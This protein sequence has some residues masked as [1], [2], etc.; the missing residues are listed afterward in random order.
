MKNKLSYKKC[1]FKADYEEINKELK[2]IDWKLIG[3]KDGVQDMVRVFYG[4][5]EKVI[6]EKVPCVQ[7]NKRRQKKRVPVWMTLDIRRNIRNRNK[8]WNDYR[9]YKTE[10]SL[11]LFEGCEM[12]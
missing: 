11:R 4:T 2:S 6:E 3:E 9:K 5:L 10:E 7:A 1:F 12:I 8:A